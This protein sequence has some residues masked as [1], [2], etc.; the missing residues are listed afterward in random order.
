MQSS[1]CGSKPFSPPT[2][3]A[4]DVQLPQ[5][6]QCT[7]LAV[8]PANNQPQLRKVL[9]QLES[10]T[11]ILLLLL[12][13]SRERPSASI[14]CYTECCRV[15]HLLSDRCGRRCSQWSGAACLSAAGRHRAALFSS[16]TRMLQ[17]VCFK[18]EA[19]G[20]C[21]VALA[22]QHLAPS[23]MHAA[24]SSSH[25]PDDDEV[26][27]ASLVQH[28]FPTPGRMAKAKPQHFGHCVGDTVW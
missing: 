2:P 23:R 25:G 21:R 13:P 18:P 28:E 14:T 27:N 3:T 1:R 10:S 24:Q 19:T 6:P 20:C 26:S 4:T 15:S 11:I 8:P 22:D 5:A 7:K 12:F 17:T 16:H 9:P